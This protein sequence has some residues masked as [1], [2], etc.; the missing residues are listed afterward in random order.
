MAAVT[1]ADLYTY[2]SFRDLVVAPLFT[3]SKVLSSGL[4]RLDTDSTH[5][6]IPVVSGGAATWRDELED[7]GDAGITADELEVT[8]KKLAVAQIVSSEAADDADAAQTLGRAMASAAANAVDLAFFRGGGAKGPDGLTGVTIGSVDAAPT[9]LD[10]YTD[11]I[12]QVEAAGATP[13]VIWMSPT[14]WGTIAKI[15]TGTGSNQ[16]VLV[17]Q[18][19]PG[20]APARSIAGVPVVVTPGVPDNEAVVADARRIVVVMRRDGRVEV[21]RSVKFLNDGVAVRLILRLAFAMPY[22]GAVVRIKDVA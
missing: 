4:T 15:K 13:S 17:P 16:P 1:T 12:T 18:T 21:D 5:V 19:N 10:A 11:A 3:E 22:V 9:G 8:P 6:T 7:L 2:Q 14:T 20:A